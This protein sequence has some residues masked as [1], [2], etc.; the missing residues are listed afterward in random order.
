[1]NRNRKNWDPPTVL[2]IGFTLII[3]IGTTLLSLPIASKNGQGLPWVDAFF[4]ATSA[5]CVTG[6][7]VIDTGNSYTLFGQIVILTLI[8][9]GGLG[10]MTFATLFAIVLGK[11]VS[12]QERLL[13]QESLN[14]TSV[15]GIIRLVKRILVFTLVIETLGGIL[16]A[17]PFA[18]DYPLDRAIYFGFFHAISNFNNAG[19]DL[20][21]DFR[22]FTDYAGHLYVNIVLC[23][24]ILLGGI[25][26]IVLNELYEYR[27]TKRF[28]LHTKLVLTTSFTLTTI[29]TFLIF[30]FEYNN[31]NTLQPL[32]MIDKI[33]SSLY[34]AISPRSAGSNT[35]NIPD[36]TQST[37]F[38]L[39]F[40]MFIG[41][42]PGSFGGGIK[43]ST[44]AVLI[45]AVW[46]QIKG[47]SD[48]TFFKRRIPYSLIYRS[49]TV[50]TT[51]LV[52]MIGVTMLL[53][54]SEHEQKVD[55]LTILFEATSAANI[56]GLS[57]GLTPSLSLAGKIIIS[58]TMFVG[59]LG[60]LTI[61][62][63]IARKRKP[64]PF[65]YPE[66]KVMIG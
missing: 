6:L 56:T 62:F 43:T 14:N 66:G 58:L 49:L 39:I 64:D 41:A 29:G 19:F 27:K 36:L 24:L 57:M 45:G 20:M 4:T 31:P 13:L 50:A 8:Q 38:L 47:K 16:L 17:I 55:F 10:F 22:S 26:F 35:L 21:G 63:A 2:V 7:V 18:Y 34:Q 46:S 65:R 60:P 9:V 48:V 11:R 5:T 44:F 40:L 37:Q 53:T 52:I 54:I 3:L 30:F 42:S 15:E 32:S 51:A 61:A 12:F 23:T 25:G 1:M 59:R 28:S 33:L